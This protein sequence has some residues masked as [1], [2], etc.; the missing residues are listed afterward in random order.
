[1]GLKVIP[2]EKSEGD[3]TG[4]D[5]EYHQRSCVLLSIDWSQQ[6][7]RNQLTNPVEPKGD[8]DSRK[9]A[10]VG[11]F[12]FLSRVWSIIEEA[13]QVL[14][15]VDVEGEDEAL[16]DDE[17]DQCQKV[18]A[19]EDFPQALKVWDVFFGGALRFADLL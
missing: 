5:C 6:Q 1:M 8:V 9:L 14:A 19:L 7:R 16:V 4:P 3:D 2:E 15:D 13:G 17:R 18:T 11:E 12:Y 10:F